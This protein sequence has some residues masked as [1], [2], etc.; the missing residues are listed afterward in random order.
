M[1]IAP[2]ALLLSQPAQR[3]KHQLTGII[4]VLYHGGT[5]KQTLDIIAAVKFMVREQSSS[6]VKVARRVSEVRRFTQ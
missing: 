5:E 2:E 3:S 1:D 6:G 4:R